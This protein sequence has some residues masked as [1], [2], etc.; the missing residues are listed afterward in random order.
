[1]SVKNW[2]KFII[3]GLVWGS[4]FLSIKIVL[5]KSTPYT[6]VALRVFFALV[7]LSIMLILT[8]QSFPLRSKWWIFLFL[9]AFN[10]AIP[11]ILISWAE[12]YIPSAIAAILNGTPPLFT[13]IIAAIFLS[14][15][16]FTIRKVA[17]LIIGFS[18]VIILMSDQ[19]GNGFGNYTFG[20]IAMLIAAMFY[21]GGAVFA[22]RF[23]KGLAPAT[24]AFGQ[25]ITANLIIWP[26]ALWGQE[27]F[28]LPSLPL[29]WFA[30]A[31]MGILGTGLAT[32]L[33]YSLLHSVGPTK[34]ML[35]SYIFPV[36]GAILG[37]IFL[38]ETFD[39][40]MVVGSA[41][42]IGGV[43]IVNWQK[44]VKSTE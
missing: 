40:R 19:L 34:T 4:S 1:M 24:Q 29:T 30:L 6:L 36:V 43:V 9:G 11:F 39:W 13:I 12:V 16:R 23:T 41:V 25:Q 5:Q 20:L 32:M 15:D 27:Q 22:R 8:R 3:L 18:G 17:G 42:I 44:P 21:G 33:Y 2:F 38:N 28:V 37:L 35:V 31:F 14:D 26:I 10:I 7:T